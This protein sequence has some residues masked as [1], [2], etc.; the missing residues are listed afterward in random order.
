MCEE[1]RHEGVVY[2]LGALPIIRALVEKTILTN[3]RDQQFSWTHEMKRLQKKSST[4]LLST[5]TRDGS[6]CM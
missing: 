5:C 3:Q 4:T 1:A 2:T 6:I